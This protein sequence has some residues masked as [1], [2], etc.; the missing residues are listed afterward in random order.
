MV[1]SPKSRD[2]TAR[3]SSIC[4]TDLASYSNRSSVNGEKRQMR[5][6]IIVSVISLAS[7]LVL[8]AVLVF[9]WTQVSQAQTRGQQP[10]QAAGARG[11]AGRGIVGGGAETN[12]PSVPAPP[13][14][15]P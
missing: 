15:K 8:A 2:R 3:L 11:A 10:N 6:R 14:W 7:L 13:G 4:Q 1:W 12:A 5:K 9:S